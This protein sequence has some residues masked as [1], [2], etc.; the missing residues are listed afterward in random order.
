MQH[1][2]STVDITK[3]ISGNLP[4]E[5]FRIGHWEEVRDAGCQK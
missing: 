3:H 2:K 1:L 5:S 4:G